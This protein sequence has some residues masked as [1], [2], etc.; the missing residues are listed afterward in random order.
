M[1]RGPFQPDP[2]QRGTSDRVYQPNHTADA[3]T[4]GTGAIGDA[5]RSFSRALGAAAEKAWTREGQQDAA[6]AV[7]SGQPLGLKRE[8][9]IREESFNTAMREQMLAQ[10]TTAYADALDKIETEKGDNLAQYAEARQAAR[11]AFT[12]TGDPALDLAF[13][14][15]AM[16]ADAAGDQR[17][18]QREETRRVQLGR[19]AFVET[20]TA[21]QTILGRAIAGAGFDEPGGQRVAAALGDYYTRL[22]RYG[23]REAFTIGGVEFAADPTRADA[24]SAEELAR[25]AGAAA[26]QA[27]TAWIIGAADQ[28]TDP[29]AK[30][31]YAA[32]IQERWAAGDAAFAGLDAGDM[33]RIGGQLDG[34]ARRAESDAASA[35]A[36]AGAEARDLL[37][38][39]EY[40]GDVDP[41]VMRAKA[42]QSG[43][44]GLMAEIEY[45][46]TY[47]FSTS[48]RE[49]GQGGGAGGIGGGG[50]D[51]WVGVL[52]DNLEGPGFVGND[53]G[54]GRAQFGITEA[55]HPE[56]WRDGK[57]DRAEA[58]AIYRR[59]YWNAIGG[60]RLPPELAFVAASSAVIGGVGTARDLL[61]QSGGD[62]ERFLQLE[63]ARFRRL[64]REDPAQY[65]DDLPGWL[66]R[67]GK[68]R[69]QLGVMRQ[70]Q[71]E[72]DGFAG[73][74]LSYAQG[75][76]NRS[77]IIGVAAM[78]PEGAFAEGPE[79][80]AWG[81]ALR[82]RQAQ[83]QELSR[84]YGVPA[85][86]FTDAETAAYKARFEQ[87]PA[88]IV[89]FAV[90]AATTLGGDGARQAMTELGRGGVAGADL[91]LGWL[92]TNP[93]NRSIVAGVIEG[94]ALRQSGAKAPD[95]GDEET[96]DEALTRF[97]PALSAQP[98]LAPAIRSL[99]EDFAIADRSRG[100][101][102]P[103]SAYLNSA[104]GATN[105][106]GHRYGGLATV[107][108]APTVAPSWMRADMLDDALEVA[109]TLWAAQDTGPV[110]GN[111]QEMPA[112]VVAGYR[113]RALPNGNYRL[114]N[115]ETGQEARARNGSAFEFNPNP[116]GFR[117]GLSR[118][119]PG[120]VLGAGR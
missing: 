37:R 5:A 65:A 6:D 10:R 75:S 70:Q 89:S 79:A 88:A 107:N 83:G 55:S 63:E 61:Q 11:A 24:V 34:D 105:W 82:Q 1:A 28:I 17:V 98:D 19:G 41:E 32:Q 14:R 108:G 47:G 60:D 38:A 72:A 40:G 12:S 59:D 15:A 84:R 30:R 45:R 103:A 33:N 112:N 18:R 13:N 87:D 102:L 4:L 20:A 9:G 51:G 67:I 68:V 73:D 52:L 106:N 21:G 58:A 50:F 49:A 36:A 113:L 86:M 22:S 116:T 44:P 101:N 48:P 66:N 2:F 29:A 109:A 27:R 120:S 85:R 64:A 16:I 69:G 80:Q 118:R 81:A 7:A 25:V 117:E 115:R 31:A 90:N 8:T 3:S 97:A 42:A 119:L 35:M 95:W 94:R 54:R 76:R 26:V 46:M 39:L 56:A 53:N 43:D 110:Y 92:A 74:P 91:H 99:A 93:R 57:V 62:P 77:P 23:P 114:V 111:G 104:L 96:L 71:R 100:R 78:N